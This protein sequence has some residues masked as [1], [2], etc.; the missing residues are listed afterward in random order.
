MEDSRLPFLLETTIS[1]LKAFERWELP[2]R[3]AGY[4]LLKRAVEKKV[5]ILFDHSSAIIIEKSF[6]IK[7]P[8]IELFEYI[9]S[10]NY[11]VHFRYIFVYDNEAQRRVI[12]RAKETGRIVPVGYI[13]KR[14]EILN[15]L[16]AEY[17]ELCT[18]YKQIEQCELKL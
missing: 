5:N 6:E 18:S 13:E 8:H 10:K 4:E 12:R 16:R 15:L 9:L 11:K 3:I 17:K 14:I 1:P 2:A 7:K